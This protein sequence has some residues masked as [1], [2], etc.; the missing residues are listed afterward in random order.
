[1]AT[2]RCGTCGAPVHATAITITETEIRDGETVVTAWPAY[3][4]RVCAADGLAHEFALPAATPEGT[5][6]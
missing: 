5:D 3:C 2:R 6:A 1:M 4:S